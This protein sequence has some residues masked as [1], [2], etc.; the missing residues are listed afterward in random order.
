MERIDMNELYVARRN[1]AQ[2][3][4]MQNRSRLFRSEVVNQANQK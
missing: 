2:T 4:E 1:Q 3:R